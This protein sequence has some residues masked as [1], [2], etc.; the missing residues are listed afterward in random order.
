MDEKD[1]DAIRLDAEN[2][3]LERFEDRQYFQKVQQHSPKDDGNYTTVSLRDV[4]CQDW[5]D[6]RTFWNNIIAKFWAKIEALNST[7]LTDGYRLLFKLSDL[8]LVQHSKPGFRPF[9]KQPKHSRSVIFNFKRSE[10]KKGCT[11]VPK[12]SSPSYIIQHSEG[13][14]CFS[15]KFGLTQKRQVQIMHQKRNLCAADDAES[16]SKPWPAAFT[17]SSI[18]SPCITSPPTQAPFA[19]ESSRGYY[20]KF[21]VYQH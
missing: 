2:E 21:S 17:N 13:C 19:Y 9:I 15:R 20:C 7:T 10:F 8:K 3:R 14:V 6:F 11:R 1:K 16:V 18:A 5:P 4:L 12:S